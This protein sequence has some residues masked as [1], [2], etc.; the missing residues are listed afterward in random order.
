VPHVEQLV[1][2]QYPIKIP[3]LKLEQPDLVIRDVPI[4]Q[5]MTATLPIN[6]TVT[7]RLPIY[8]NGVPI[9]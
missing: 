7:I 6:I 5:A 2:N 3:T 4:P 8:S 1:Q 9:H